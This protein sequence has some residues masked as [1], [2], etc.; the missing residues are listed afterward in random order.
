MVYGY[1][2]LPGACKTL[3]VVA[4]LW[5]LKQR[6][7]RVYANIP[8]IDTRR[9]SHREFWF[10]GKMSIG[11]WNE[12]TFGRS[13]SDGFVSSLEEVIRLRKGEVL[14]DEVHTWAGSHKWQSIPD[15]IRSYLSMQRKDGINIHWT[16]QDEQRVFNQIRELTGVMWECARYGPWSVQQAINLRQNKKLDRRVFWIGPKWWDLYDTSFVIGDAKGQGG[17]S[18]ANEHYRRG[19]VQKPVLQRLLDRE[20]LPGGIVRYVHGADVFRPGEQAA[21]APGLFDAFDRELGR[22]LPWQPGL[23]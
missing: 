15:A 2:G 12:R 23:A 3:S 4:H 16:A 21:E 7:R 19:K 5:R 11:P 17:R 6:G 22:V 20:E 9:K 13:W 10:F 8:L 1:T 14:L 18:G